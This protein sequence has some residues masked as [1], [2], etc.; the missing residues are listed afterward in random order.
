M[1]LSRSNTIEAGTLEI[2]QDMI[3]ERA[4][5]LPK[6]DDSDVKLHSATLQQ[7]A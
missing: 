2:Q 4:L 3:A 1:V 7:K 5:G 6:S